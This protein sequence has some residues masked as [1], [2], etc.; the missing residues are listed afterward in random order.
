MK[1]NERGRTS[2]DVLNELRTSVVCA[3]TLGGSGASVV[4]FV[5]DDVGWRDRVDRAE[6]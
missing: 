6:S 5:A 2:A 4:G 1:E 3:I